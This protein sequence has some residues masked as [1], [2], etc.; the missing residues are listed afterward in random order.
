MT[1]KYSP[2][3]NEQRRLLVK[4]IYE[5]GLSIRQAAI[6]STI[7]YPTAKAINKIYMSEKR[8]DKKQHRFRKIAPN[9]TSKDATKNQLTEAGSLATDKND[10]GSQSTS[11]LT[12]NQTIT[13]LKPIREELSFASDIY[14]SLDEEMIDVT[15]ERIG[16]ARRQSMPFDHFQIASSKDAKSQPDE[17]ARSTPALTFTEP[18]TPSLSQVCIKQSLSGRSSTPSSVCSTE[19]LDKRIFVGAPS[20][21][22]V[23]KKT[24]GQETYQANLGA[25]IQTRQES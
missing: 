12:R 2:V 13:M 4:L 8:I 14:E 19:S 9:T 23:D 6:G 10:S 3:S 11:A 1:K 25:A 16:D 22:L 17:D 5:D 7:Y 21:S 24:E 20:L 15:E 18:T